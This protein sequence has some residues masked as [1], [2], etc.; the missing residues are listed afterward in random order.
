MVEAL[1]A[2]QDDGPHR[3]CPAGSVR[4]GKIDGNNT[5]TKGAARSREF[6]EQTNRAAG[7]G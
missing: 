6:V 4:G 7:A 3:R 5:Q 2:R 1:G